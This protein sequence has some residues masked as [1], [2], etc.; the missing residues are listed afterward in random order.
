MRIAPYFANCLSATDLD[1]LNI[2]IIRNT[3]YKAYLDDFMKF[4]MEIGGGTATVMKELLQFEADRRALTITINSL[5]TDLSKEERA[6]LY[7]S[8]GRLYPDGLARL[9]RADDVDQVRVVCESYAVRR[10]LDES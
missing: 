9:A 7:P 2:E 5:G 8:C 1:E 10:Y 6:K 3:L 4:C